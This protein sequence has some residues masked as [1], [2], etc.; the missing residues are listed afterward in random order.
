MPDRLWLSLG[1][2]I[3]LDLILLYYLYRTGLERKPRK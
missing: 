3:A 2:L 1:G